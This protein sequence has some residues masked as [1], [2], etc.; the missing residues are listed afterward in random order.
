MAFVI[1]TAGHIDHGK[2]AL[3]RRLTGQDTDKLP[4]EKARGISIDLGFAHFDLGFGA[5]IGLVDVPGHERFIRNMVAGV[6]GLNLVLFVIAADD[7]VMPQ[8]EEHLAILTALGVENV[9]FVVTK[10]DRVD[11]VRLRDL[12]EEIEIF[13][14]GSRL[15][16][17]P[18]VEVS[19]ATGAGIDT[20]KSVISARLKGRQ[21]KS[22]EGLFRMPIDRVFSVHGRGVVVTGTVVSGEI[23][24]GDELAIAPDIGRFRVR[25]L[26]QHGSDVASGR[27]GER[28]AINLSGGA[29]SRLCRGYV[30]V[31]PELD[32]ST[33]RF[34]AQI[35]VSALI[36]GKLK[37]G[38]QHG[39][40]VRLHLGTAERRGTVA[41]LG[42]RKTLAQGVSDFAQIHLSE[43]M[44]ALTE[45]RF[46]LR[47]EQGKHT[48]GGGC[49]LDPL[50]QKSGRRSA[51]RAGQLAAVL[52]ADFALA[53][54]LMIAQ[55]SGL[56]IEAD[57]VGF[58]LNLQPDTR[59]IMVNATDDLLEL[60]AGSAVWVSTETQLNTLI[61]KVKVTLATAH[62]LHP[63]LPGLGL[64][65]LHQRT[66]SRVDP[67]LFAAVCARAIAK[68]TLQS[69]EGIFALNSHK[70]TLNE[71]LQTAAQE[72][73]SALRTTPFSP[74]LQGQISAD[75]KTVIAFL[76]RENSIIRVTANMFFTAEA[77]AQA[78]EKLALHFA[79]NHDISAAEFRDIL[80]TSRK[81][82]LSL[83]ESFDKSGRTIRVGDRRIR[84][85]L[86]GEKPDL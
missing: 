62:A 75:D 39:Q 19:N 27:A 65:V 56:A 60:E 22:A 58:R 1:G 45:D 29:P 9:I 67:T 57:A 12:R 47:D 53:A 7:G 59:Q 80:G 69:H 66:A 54:R 71:R 42:A 64:D 50:G 41:L 13:L 4:D 73:L 83:L 2:T 78:V 14:D 43:P 72:L 25:G 74:P 23:R 31:A 35:T 3:V 36:G 68:G 70:T 15:V 26:Q 28:L 30:A 86:G 16:N 52:A 49:V 40:R 24:H 34:D 85:H 51:E 63:S 21:T 17:A 37:G 76:E 55:R 33:D 11:A 61:E 77:F 20:L 46:I 82:A 81:Y 44:H 84:G 5:P 10:I 18:I 6:H 38:L 48:L 79:D 32:R 8:S